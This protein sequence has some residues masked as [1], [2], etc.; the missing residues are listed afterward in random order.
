MTTYKVIGRTTPREL[1][2]SQDSEWRLEQ[3]ADLQTKYDLFHLSLKQIILMW[4]DYSD[5][6]CAGWLVDDVASVEE[7]F[8]VILEEVDGGS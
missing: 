1:M 3:A 8:G 7:V 6:M 2:E 4:E 5:S